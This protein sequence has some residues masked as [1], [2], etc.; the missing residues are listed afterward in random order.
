MTNHCMRHRKALAA[1][2][3]PAVILLEVIKI[4]NFAKGSALN[5][6]L[7]RNLCLDMDAAHI[8]LL[9]HNEIR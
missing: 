1:Q 5:T 6:R 7:F 3:L 2:S 4:L 9:F 8:D